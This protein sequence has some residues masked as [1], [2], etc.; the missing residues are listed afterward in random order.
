[1][2]MRHNSISHFD[3][4]MFNTTSFTLINCFCLHL[5]SHPWIGMKSR[6]RYAASFLCGRQAQPQT[7]GSSLR[8]NS[9][10]VFI[11]FYLFVYMCACIWTQAHSAH[12][13]V[14]GKLVELHFLLLRYGSRYWNPGSRSWT[15][16][17]LT[18]ESSHPPKNFIFRKK[19]YNFKG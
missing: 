3:R 10:R 5:C 8:N 15:K 1:M 18:S 4:I 19:N 9:I 2:L 6:K 13:E 12:G 11:E 7:P 17:P 14:S 16:L